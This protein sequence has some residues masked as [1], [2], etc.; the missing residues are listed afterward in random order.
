MGKILKTGIVVVLLLGLFAFLLNINVTTGGGINYKVYTVKIPLYLKVL[1]FFDR[2]YNFK[3]LTGRIV[4]DI[5]GEEEKALKILDWTFS[6]MKKQ[7]EG[8]PVMDDHTWNIIVQG[9]GV[10]DSFNIVY[11]T[12]CNYAGLD[13]FVFRVPR[14]KKGGKSSV[15]LVKINDEWSVVDPHN[16]IYFRNKDSNLASVEDMKSENW[17]LI[18]K[19]DTVN[20]RMDY[21]ILPK[22]LPTKIE[23]DLNTA[24]IQSPWNRLRFQIRNLIQ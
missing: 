4:G 20:F 22:L 18:Q 17:R 7:P 3:W 6:H 21:Q 15:T 8:L 16:G 10:H 13:A 1:N 11:A 2:H 9:Y 5:K 24:N 19:A 12:L 14:D 23:F